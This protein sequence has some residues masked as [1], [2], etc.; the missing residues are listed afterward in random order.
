MH[1]AK[2]IKMSNFIR[3]PKMMNIPVTG[4]WNIQ[5]NLLPYYEC[6]EEDFFY[7]SE[8]GR[9]EIRSSARILASQ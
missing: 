5:M 2:S 1:K 6:M 3:N 7:W 9:A 8:R 4:S